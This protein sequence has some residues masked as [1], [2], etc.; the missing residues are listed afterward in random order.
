MAVEVQVLQPPL[1]AALLS[2]QIEALAGVLLLVLAGTEALHGQ[3]LVFRV[4]GVGLAVG[5]IPVHPVA[6]PVVV[7]LGAQ[8]LIDLEDQAGVVAV[9]QMVEAVGAVLPPAG[10]GAVLGS[11]GSTIA[12][13]SPQ[14]GTGR[15]VAD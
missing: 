10:A 11:T 8:S 7:S 2:G 5:R 13:S 4:V 9:R 15:R 6:D 12:G 3:D 1:V 14:T